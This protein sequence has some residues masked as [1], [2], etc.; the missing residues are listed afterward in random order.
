[1][2]GLHSENM[3]MAALWPLLMPLDRLI[4]EHNRSPVLCQRTWSFWEPCFTCCR[5]LK[6]HL[7]QP[8]RRRIKKKAGQ[9][10]KICEETEWSQQVLWPYY[11]FQEQTDKAVHFFSLFILKAEKDFYLTFSLSICRMIFLKTLT[12]DVIIS[13]IFIF[14][15]WVTD[16]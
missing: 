11:C 16:C 9:P 2:W 10:Y 5:G 12:M 8:F 1:M 14:T 6:H 7:N 13:K 15:I 4:L 3:L